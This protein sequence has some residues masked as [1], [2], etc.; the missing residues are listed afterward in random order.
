MFPVINLSLNEHIKNTYESAKCYQQ[1]E[2]IA[3][4][5]NTPHPSGTLGLSLPSVTARRLAWKKR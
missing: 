2:N 5:E 1:S 4:H 3:R